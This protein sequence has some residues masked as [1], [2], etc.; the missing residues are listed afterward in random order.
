[1]RRDI[2]NKTNQQETG[3]S[4]E[5]MIQ[6][7]GR[8][9]GIREALLA[10]VVL[11][12]VLSMG[13]ERAHGSEFC[14]VLNRWSADKKIADQALRARYEG[15]YGRAD[16]T[17]R[18]RTWNVETVCEEFLVVVPLWADVGPPI[19]SHSGENLFEDSNGGTWQ[20]E[21]GGDGKAAAVQMTGPDGTV[22][23]MKRLGDPRR[24]E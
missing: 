1:M 22:S 8:R 21:V 9:F 6:R 12:S 2:I 17:D 10:A 14:E 4:E 23:E 19:L 7:V 13:A 5:T 24:F 11:G 20:F 16:D 3:K 15:E 18:L